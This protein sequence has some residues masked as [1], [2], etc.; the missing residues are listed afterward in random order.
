MRIR[1]HGCGFV[2]YIIALIFQLLIKQSRNVCIDLVSHEGECAVCP[3]VVRMC[4]QT[5]ALSG[6]FAHMFDQL[7]TLH[8][9]SPQTAVVK[10]RC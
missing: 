3:L 5:A 7:V 4:C 2:D 9:Q 1:R 6:P 8:A 10:A